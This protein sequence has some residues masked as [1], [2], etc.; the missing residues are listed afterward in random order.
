MNMHESMEWKM[1]CGK[2][3][4]AV[5]GWMVYGVIY[6]GKKGRREESRGCIIREEV[7]SCNI[8]GGE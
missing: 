8:V 6:K 1:D 3:R 4:G 7:Q 2:E 5:D